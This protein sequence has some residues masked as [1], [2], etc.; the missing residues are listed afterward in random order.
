MPP[1][2]RITITASP[3]SCA[4]GRTAARP[5]ARAGCSGSW[6]RRSGPCASRARARRTARA[7]VGDAERPMRPASRS[8]SSHGRCSCHATRLCTC[9]I[10]TRPKSELRVDCAAPRRAGVQIFVA[11][12]S[13]RGGRRAPRRAPPPRGRTSARSRR[14]SLPLQVRPRPPSERARRL[15]RMS[16]T[17]R[18]RR[19]ARRDALHRRHRSRSVRQTQ[20][21]DEE[22]DMYTSGIWVVKAGREADFARRWQESADCVALGVPR[23]EASGCCATGRT[24]DGSSASARAG[25][26]PSRSRPP[27]ARPPTRTRWRR[28]GGCSNRARSRRST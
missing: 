3:S 12:A 14:S 17:Y 7:L 19:P 15:R 25:V 23:C 27:G 8:A 21:V 4:S 28:C 6:T 11:T 2:G 20:G 5:R 9:S 18:A 1:N 22:D 16:D 24:R 26:T 13:P 10:S